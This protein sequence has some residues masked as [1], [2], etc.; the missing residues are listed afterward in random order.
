MASSSTDS[1]GASAEPVTVDLDGLAELAVRL[2]TAA[3]VLEEVC[4]ALGSVSGLAVG[5][6]AVHDA[7]QDLSTTWDRA[8]GGVAS[9]A[10]SLDAGVVRAQQAY[11]ACEVRVGGLV[12]APLPAWGPR[13]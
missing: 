10:R 2:R 1:P 7:L 12:R 4:T 5:A 11:G 8:V 9:G 6:H 3:G 13:R